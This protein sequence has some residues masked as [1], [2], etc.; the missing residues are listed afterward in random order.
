MNVVLNSGY[1]NMTF[2]KRTFN[3]SPQ[4][5]YLRP[6]IS[7]ERMSE[8]A[9]SPR[10]LSLISSCNMASSLVQ[11]KQH[12]KKET[13]VNDNDGTLMQLSRFANYP[14]R[15]IRK[16]T[17]LMYRLKTCYNA[18]VETASSASKEISIA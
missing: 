12:F 6:I 16:S 2:S 13:I 18:V 3:T 11:P 4:W 10:R 9:A 15:M 8:W 17:T 7:K 14:I 1:S 5:S